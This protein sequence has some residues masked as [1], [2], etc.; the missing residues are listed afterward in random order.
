V[1]VAVQPSAYDP[2]AA[3]RFSPKQ[4]FAALL[5]YLVGANQE[6]LRNLQAQSFG[7]LAVCELQQLA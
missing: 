7:G 6:R 5:D 3:G 1:I 2:I 4:T